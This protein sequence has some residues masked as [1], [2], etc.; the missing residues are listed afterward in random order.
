MVNGVDSELVSTYS[1]GRSKKK[2]ARM[3]MSETALVDSK[4]ERA[5]REAMR[6]MTCIGTGLTRWGGGSF[7]FRAACKRWRRKST[8]LSP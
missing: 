2:N 7:F 4:V 8:A 5:A 1:P 6:R 3:I